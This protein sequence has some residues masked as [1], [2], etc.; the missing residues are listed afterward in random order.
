MKTAPSVDVRAR[1]QHNEHVS[2]ASHRAADRTYD[3]SGLEAIRNPRREGKHHGGTCVW[4]DSEQLG[5]SLGYADAIRALIEA[6]DS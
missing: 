2:Y 4:W 5:I 6:P 3:P 1:R